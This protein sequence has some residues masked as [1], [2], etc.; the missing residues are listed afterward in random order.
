MSID[1]KLTAVFIGSKALGLSVFKSIYSVSQSMRW[2]IIHPDD[3]NDPRSAL[4][5]FQNFARL[6]DIDLL[7][8]ASP[9]AAKQMVI[10]FAPDIG[11]VCGWYWLIDSETIGLVPNGLWGVHNSILPKYRGGAP[12]VW[13][14]LNGDKYAG[15]SVFKISEGMDDGDV[16]HQVKVEVLAEDNVGSVLK[17][18]EGRL[19]EE[20]PDK[21][22]KLISCEARIFS[23]DDSEATYCGQRTEVDGLVD[24]SLNA[25]DVHNF[26]RAQ[27]P[28]YPCAYSH[29]NNKK[30]RF[31]DSQ[32]FDG[33]YFGTPGQVLS[34]RP[35][36]VVISCGGHTAI[37]VCKLLVD[38]V[39]VKS[40]KVL[41]SVTDRLS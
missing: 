2:I 38:D 4:T 39:E 5:E 26:I 35:D 18:I 20:L 11:F 25:V 29:I 36:A 7:V 19:I 17:K 28:P 24:W 22:V 9:A 40:S 23:Q 37:E 8:A 30:I 32:V 21:W 12:L 10:D 13:S 31:V 16:L 41:L 1:I 27:S 6:C 33:I 14:I 15:S 3:S 34:R